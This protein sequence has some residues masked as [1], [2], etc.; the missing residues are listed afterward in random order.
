MS[1]FKEARTLILESY[2][3]HVIDDDELIRL[4]D[5]TFSKNPEFS[6]EF[7]IINLLFAIM[8][9]KYKNTETTQ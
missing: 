6:N 2:L 1:T 4:H 3:D 7:I 8:T 9:S 5:E